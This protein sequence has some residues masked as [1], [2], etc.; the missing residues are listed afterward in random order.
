M[1]Y[2]FGHYSK[3]A[4]FRAEYYAY[5]PDMAKLSEFILVDRRALQTAYG[6]GEAR[7]LAIGAGRVPS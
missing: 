4:L 2:Y 7:L 1:S 5:S 3:V 6:G